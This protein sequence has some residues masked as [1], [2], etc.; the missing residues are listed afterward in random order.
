MSMN[1]TV[2]QLRIASDLHEAENA[3]DT[4]LLQQSKLMSTLLAARIDTGVA[5]ALGQEALLRLA[6][7]QQSM[8][9][10]SN[11]LARVHGALLKV[12]ADVLGYEG[13]PDEARPMGVIS[14][15]A[16]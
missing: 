16:A 1:E 12:Q 15:Q 7:A 6:R 4:A 9:T 11:D 13:C 10:V 5:P 14:E 2:A 3:V 8:L